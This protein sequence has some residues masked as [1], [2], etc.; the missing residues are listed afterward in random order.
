MV[1]LTCANI[2]K[3]GKKYND[4]FGVWY[5]DFSFKSVI[6]ETVRQAEK[7]GY[8]PVVYDLGELGIGEPFH[9]EDETFA[10][11]GYYSTQVKEG[12]KSRS[13]FKPEV[14]KYCLNTH[15]DFTVYLDG[16]A[17]L[18][19][20]IDEIL[21]GD[22]DIGVT[23][24]KPSELE[25]EWHKRLFEI[26]KYVNAGVI[27]FNYTQAAL[28]FVDIW[29]K[30]TYEVGNDQKALN[31]LVCPEEYPKVNSILT[32]NGVRIKFFPCEQYNYTY[33]EEGL[34]PNMKIL[35]FKGMY[36]NFYPF[37]WK[38]RLYCMTIIPIKN[39]ISSV[40]KRI[41]N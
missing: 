9:V 25:T 20:S 32:I 10:K 8:K 7:C 21:T 30:K 22:Y 38:R 11:K 26:A 14:V 1:I 33:F 5:R 4:E 15:K 41:K 19:D 3:A 13:L 23:L 16:D 12:Y 31:Q 27:F 37:D 6:L 40:L 36:R 28:D 34:E 2:D 24:R 18:V 39:I 35:H 29:E 17:Q